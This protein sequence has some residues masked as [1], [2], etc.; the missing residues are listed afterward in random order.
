VVGKKRVGRKKGEEK[1]GRMT[2]NVVKRRWG[3]RKRG[4]E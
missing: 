2:G 1:G 4:G 3:S